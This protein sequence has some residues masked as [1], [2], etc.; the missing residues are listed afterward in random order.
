MKDVDFLVFFFIV[1]IF[2]SFV[3]YF[4]YVVKL[5]RFGWCVV[6]GFIFCFV[7]GWVYGDGFCC[8][9]FIVDLDIF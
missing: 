1:F 7:F 2:V 9:W 6:W 4:L 5:E 8:L 3:L